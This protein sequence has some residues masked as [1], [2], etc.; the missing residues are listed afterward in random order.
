MRDVVSV[1]GLQLRTAALEADLW[2]RTAVDQPVVCS[3]AV[4]CDVLAE[5][6]HDR[7]L[8]DSLNYGAVAKALQAHVA[9]LDL[10]SDPAAP[11][12]A[13]A[14]EVLAEQLARVV[15]VECHAP[16]VALQLERPR[17]LLS[18]EAVGVKIYR[19]RTR[20]PAD[21]AAAVVTAV[22]EVPDSLYV[23]RLSR[24]II[25]G[26]NPQERLDEQTV[27]VDLEFTADPTDTLLADMPRP[28]WRGWRGAVKRVENVSLPP[29]PPPPPP[30]PPNPTH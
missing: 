8:A 9:R 18:A 25:I 23:R 27:L 11:A 7:L 19:T 29:P 6:E 24:Q 3:L 14:L 5:A 17:A 16:N 28:G 12:P 30:F 13:V 21:D 22:A 1:T 26:L 10:E 4:E 15:L 2:Q 20:G